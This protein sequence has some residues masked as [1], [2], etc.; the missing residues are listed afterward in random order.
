MRNSYYPETPG[1]EGW[2]QGV[3]GG[4][5]AVACGG[6]GVILDGGG[7]NTYEFDYLSHG[8]GYW[9]GLGFARDFG[10]NTKRLITRTAYN[11]G[12]RAYESFQRFGCGWGCH[13]AMGFLFDDSGDDVYEARSWAPA[14]PGTA[15]WAC[16]ATSPETTTTR[17]PADRP[18]EPAPRWASASSSTTDGD[19][20][21]EGYGQGYATPGISYH[22]LPECGGNF[23]FLIDYGGKDTYGCGAEN[24]GYNQR[25]D[26]G[27][28]HHRS[29]PPG[30]DSAYGS[31]RLGPADPPP[32][33]E[34]RETEKVLA[35]GLRR[36]ENH[37]CENL[38]RPLPAVSYGELAGHSVASELG[39]SNRSIEV[40]RRFFDECPIRQITL[41]GVSAAFLLSPLALAARGDDT[42]KKADAKPAKQS[43]A[44]SAKAKPKLSPELA[45]LRDQVLKQQLAT[46]QKQT[47]NTRQNSATE[48]LSVCLAFGCNSEV[49]LEGSD[50]N[51]ING[52]ACLCWN[53]PCQGFELLGSYND[54]LAARIGYGYQEHPGEFLATLAM[55]RVPEE[56]PDPCRR[57]V[58][59]HR[60][61]GRSGK[62]RLPHRR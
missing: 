14:W 4:L 34:I 9:C 58:A 32:A 28:L 23:S 24:N 51:R 31:S 56:L 60:R 57:K 39:G 29:S 54:H 46:Q 1:Y 20:V 59:D 21:Y 41:I 62:A 36:D 48:I 44:P 55:S 2:G 25:G 61:P 38:L 37:L 22:H 12:P 16:C 40:T 50:G 19:D 3:G 52:I 18:K 35:G 47:F 43:A 53:Y 11:G 30:G 33:C 45:A 42:A 6:I 13:Y 8:G 5:R 49:S 10:G 7:E 27:R 17:P 26:G 15:R